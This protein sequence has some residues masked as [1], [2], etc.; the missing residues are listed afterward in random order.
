MTIDFSYVLNDL[1]GKPFPDGEK[2]VT[3]GSA[4]VAALMQ[5][6]QDEHGITGEEKFQR[7]A[8][9]QRVWGATLVDASSED[10]ARIKLLVGKFFGPAV[11]GPAYKALDGK[12]WVS[13]TDPVAPTAQSGQS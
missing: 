1:S 3:L 5:S 8:L 4:A 10:V 13:S 2:S 9:A 7:F 11:V 12:A 6:Y